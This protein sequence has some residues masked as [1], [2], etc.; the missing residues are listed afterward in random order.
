MNDTIRKGFT[1]ASNAASDALCQGRHLAQRGIS[2]PSKGSD[3][4]G[5]TAI[6]DA[7]KTGDGSKLSLDQADIFQSCRTIESKLV[8]AVFGDNA[9]VVTFREQRYWGKWQAPDAPTLEHSGQVDVVHRS[10]SKALI[11]DFKTLP[12]DV[13]DSPSNLQLRDLACLV[14][15]HFVVVDEVYTAI[16]QPLVTHS[17]EVCA[18]DLPS[19]ERAAAEMVARVAA[20]N[21]PDAKRVAGEVQCK[22]CLA[23]SRC[24]AY[25]SWIGGL[26][27][28]GGTVEPVVRELVFQ[29][30]MLDWTPAQRAI[31]AGLLLP[32]SKALDEIKEFLKAGVLKDPAFIPG[33]GLTPGN[34]TEK[35]TDPQAC[36]DR[37]VRLGG[38]I[39]D[40][41]KAVVIG[42]TKLKTAVNK[43]TGSVGRQLESEL[44]NLT[45]GIVEVKQNAPSLMELPKE[46]K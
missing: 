18:Y 16:I 34:K 22:F 35:I 6:H 17:P 2:E 20:S 43:V 7:L 38:K 19:L 8:S 23:K 1:S 32:A 13:P 27:P 28:A 5:G 24:G 21:Q 44:F 10:G 9:K 12:G 36:F 45:S 14:K 15:G 25:S 3:A 41:M 42:K 37:F 33:W 39:E 11:C 30:A 26:I 29:T 31:A 40:F 4:A 46:V